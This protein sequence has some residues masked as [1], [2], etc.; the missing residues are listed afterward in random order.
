MKVPCRAKLSKDFWCCTT[1][2]F[3]QRDYFSEISDIIDIDIDTTDIDTTNI[4]NL[5]LW[6][7]EEK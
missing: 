4:L 3:L 1:D 6:V 7:S 5:V 2:C